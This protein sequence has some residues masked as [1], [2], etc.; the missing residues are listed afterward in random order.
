[1]CGFAGFNGND[2]NILNGMVDAIFHRGPD[3]SGLYIGEAL[4]MG[5]RR[6]SI[7]GLV[8]GEQPVY[9]ENGTVVTVYNGEI[10]NYMAL[11][12][13]LT[14]R[15]HVFKTGTDTE[16]LVHAYEEY[17]DEF[18]SR[19]RGMFAFA[20]YDIPKKRLLIARDHFGIKPVYYYHLEPEKY[21][22]KPKV[23]VFAKRKHRLAPRKYPDEPKFRVFVKR[24]LRWHRPFGFFSAPYRRIRT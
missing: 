19:L 16:V 24:K 1:M 21:P 18:V 22:D 10:Y 5:M 2:K 11:K 9:N 8:D 12:K 6:L 15:S 4:S 20:L 17:G 23:L 13:A 14:E 3:S 7:I